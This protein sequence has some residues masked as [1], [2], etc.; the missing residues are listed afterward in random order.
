[1]I[2]IL[3]GSLDILIVRKLIGQQ[4]LRTS[5]VGFQ[6][7]AILILYMHLSYFEL[8]IV[9]VDV[10]MFNDDCYWQVIVLCICSQHVGQFLIYLILVS[11]L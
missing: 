11:I 5:V 7:L 6:I 2:Q 4:L 1:M 10:Q 3:L 9:Q 8:Q